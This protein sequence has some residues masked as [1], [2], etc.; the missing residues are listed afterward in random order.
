[1][2]GKLK[3]LKPEEI[4][5]SFVLPADISPKQKQAAD[6]E[7]VEIRRKRQS[8]MS[9]NEKLLFRLMQLRYKLEN[10]LEYEA[11]NPEYSFSY[12]LREY[13]RIIDRKDKDFA[14]EINIH[15]TRLSQLMNNRRE[16]NEDIIIRLE[17]HSDKVLPAIHWFKLVEK[18][19]EH[20]IQTNKT[21]RTREKHHVKNKLR[22]RFTSKI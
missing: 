15:H 22:I 21:L 13:L 18:G 6:R 5:D 1:M 17:I 9:D 12:F 3:D 14:R 16:P 2:K 8:Q 10:Y 4:V 19:K 7:L 20:F 11:F